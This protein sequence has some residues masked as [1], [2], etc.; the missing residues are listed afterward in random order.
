MEVQQY[1]TEVFTKVIRIQFESGGHFMEINLMI[2]EVFHIKPQ[3]LTLR[4]KPGN[5]QNP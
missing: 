3:M 2:V 1:I 4:K 5:H